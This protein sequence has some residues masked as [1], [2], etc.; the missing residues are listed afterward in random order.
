M[1]S[2]HISNVKDL[3]PLLKKFSLDTLLTHSQYSELMSELKTMLEQAYYHGNDVGIEE[4]KEEIRE[5]IKD[6]I[7]SAL[8]RL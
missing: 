5:E 4:G 2:C 8:N 3:D 1:S 7:Q 6:E